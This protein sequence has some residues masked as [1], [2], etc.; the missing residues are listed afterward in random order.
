MLKYKVLRKKLT[1]IQVYIPIGLI[2]LMLLKETR[3]YFNLP[4]LIRLSVS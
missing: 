1:G 2:Q 3:Q 4:L